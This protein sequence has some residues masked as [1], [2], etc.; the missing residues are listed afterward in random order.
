MKSNQTQETQQSQALGAH[1]CNPSFLGSWDWENQIS[2]LAW[3]KK[4]HRNPITG[5]SGVRPS[6][7]AMQE[8]EIGGSWFQANWEEKA[9]EIPSQQEKG[10]HA[11]HPSDSRKHKIIG[12]QSRLAK[13]KKEKKS[14]TLSLKKKKKAEQNGLEVWLKW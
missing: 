9:C 11:C 14:E 12:S 6:S 10:R 7:Q 2:R 5:C 8:A 3:T 13:Q 4:V 1:T